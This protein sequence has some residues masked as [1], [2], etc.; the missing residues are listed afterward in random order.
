MVCG[1][2]CAKVRR[3]PQGVKLKRNRPELPEPGPYVSIFGASGY[4]NLQWRG[5]PYHHSTTRSHLVTGLVK[6][7]DPL[8]SKR[9]GR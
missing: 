4:F 3:S 7:L 5:E 1:W 6:R 2:G 9:Y 8:L